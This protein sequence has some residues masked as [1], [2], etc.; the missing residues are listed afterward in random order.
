MTKTY[1]DPQIQQQHPQI[2]KQ[3]RSSKTSKD[4]KYTDQNPKAHTN[5]LKMT[6]ID[7]DYLK[8]PQKSTKN[9]KN[10]QRP[11]RRID[12]NQPQRPTNIDKNLQKMFTYRPTKNHK[13]RQR[14]RLKKQ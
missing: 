2:K 12:Y 1:Q 7:N 3:Q 4:R 9:D 14:L 11:T 10:F 13:D 5:Q 6:K 8:D